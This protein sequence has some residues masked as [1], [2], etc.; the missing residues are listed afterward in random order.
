MNITGGKYNGRK[1]F[2]PNENIT[3]PTLSKVRMGVYN[4]LYSLLGSFEDC[5]FIDAFA[6]SGIMGLEALSR[7]FKEVIAFELNKDAYKII[8]QNYVLLG[9]KVDLK[10]G[11]SL[12]LIP[13]IDKNFDVIYIDPPYESDLYEQIFLLINDIC[14][15]KKINPVIIAEHSGKIHTKLFNEIKTKNYGGKFISFYRFS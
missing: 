3:R 9:E 12:K 8:R 11:D 1:L 15:E 7:G 10:K 4:T 5:V 2:V 14:E 6:G 13:K